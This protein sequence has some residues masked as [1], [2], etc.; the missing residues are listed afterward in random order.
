MIQR[1]PELFWIRTCYFEFS[2]SKFDIFLFSNQRTQ[3]LNVFLLV[4]SRRNAIADFS[5]SI[6][7]NGNAKITF[8]VVSIHYIEVFLTM[9]IPALSPRE[10]ENGSFQNF[11]SFCHIYIC[12]CV[13]T[14]TLV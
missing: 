11:D 8:V 5:F 14:G 2:D 13:L 6:G 7:A 1:L 9:M 3:S 10:C 4:Q 12:V